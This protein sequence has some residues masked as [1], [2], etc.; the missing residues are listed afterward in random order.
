MNADVSSLF[1][2]DTSKAICFDVPKIYEMEHEHEYYWSNRRAHLIHLAKMKI[3]KRNSILRWVVSA[4]IISAIL[5]GTIL[6]SLLIGRVIPNIG[7]AVG[8]SC[9]VVVMK[10]SDWLPTDLFWIKFKHRDK[11]Y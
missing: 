10:V 3:A 2:K 6:L 5:I 8:M 11:I 9:V 1:V 7:F 4:L